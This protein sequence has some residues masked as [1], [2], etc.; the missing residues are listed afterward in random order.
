MQGEGWRRL[1]I[2]LVHPP[3]TLGTQDDGVKKAQNWIEQS[4]I[5]TDMAYTLMLDNPF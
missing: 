1:V 5:Q 2:S 4:Q 3:N